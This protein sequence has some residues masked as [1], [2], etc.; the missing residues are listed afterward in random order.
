MHHQA[1]GDAPGADA[2]QLFVGDPHMPG[3]N[4]LA[5]TAEFLRVA[6]TEQSDSGGLGP[7]FDRDMAVLIPVIGVGHNFRIDK[8]AQLRAPLVVLFAQIRVGQACAVKV[9]GHSLFSQR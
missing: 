5:D 7:Q 4:T 2:R 8:L 1:G 9:Q 3:I 6:Q